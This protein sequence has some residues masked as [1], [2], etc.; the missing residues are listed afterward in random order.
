MPEE[1]TILVI[2]D[3]LEI[4]NYLKTLITQFGYRSEI[5][6]SGKDGLQTI[7][8]IRPELVILDVVMPD[9]DGLEVLKQIQEEKM[10]TSVIMLSGHRQ[11]STV[12]GAMKLGAA[13]FLNK[14]F[15]PEELQF[16]ISKVLERRNLISEVQ[17]L[18]KQVSE[19]NGNQI[20]FGNSEKMGAIKE[21]IEQV[22]DTDITILIRG[23]SGTGKG[24][25]ARFIYMNSSRRDR[26]FV[27]V[28]CAALPAEL[29]ES[30]LFGYERGAF[31]GAH[32]KKPGKFEFANHGTIFLD[33][34]G[35]IPPALQAKLLQV[36]QDGEFA[37]LGSEQDVRV[38]ARVI[39]ASNR[40][41]EA[42]VARGKFREDL[43][44]RLN[45]V[46]ITVPPLRERMEEI[47]ILTEHFLQKYNRKYNKDY[48]KIS[49][50][51]MGLFMQYNWPGNVRELE[52]MIKRVVVLESEKPIATEFL[53]K[54]EDKVRSERKNGSSGSGGNMTASGEFSFI[55]P[56]LE[57]KDHNFTLREISKEASKRAEKE[58][59]EKILRQTNW[60]RKKTAEILQVSYKA[61]L[62]KIKE[63]KI[64]KFSDF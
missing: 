44:F 33:E 42:E 5:A 38:D 24:L 29:L 64:D 59:I 52:N 63:N 46:N 23:E 18:K 47:P 10:D 35:E 30:E 8:R 50:E 16:T 45:V 12:V 3:E 11:T 13:D 1:A 31:T 61:L 21:I 20:L 51:T 9:M 56:L 62:Y 58:L 54:E 25:I 14:P 53:L 4:G 39:A 19:Q 26:H 41:L 2:D 37:P 22:A 48:K 15:D 32:K 34:I 57:G 17:R 27:N 36:L 49:K 6:T 55:D 40:D 28:N 43:Y 7:Q 60:S